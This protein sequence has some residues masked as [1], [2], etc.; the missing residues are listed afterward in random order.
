MNVRPLTF[1][2]LP[3][4][5]SWRVQEQ[6]RLVVQRTAEPLIDRLAGSLSATVD[7]GS[8]TYLLHDGKTI[9]VYIHLCIPGSSRV[10]RIQMM[11]FMHVAACRSRFEIPNSWRWEWCVPWFQTQTQTQTQT[12]TQT[13]TQTNFSH[14]C[15][16]NKSGWTRV[17]GLDIDENW[18]GVWQT[19]DWETRGSLFRLGLCMTF[20]KP[21]VAKKWDGVTEKWHTSCRLTLTRRLQ[22]LPRNFSLGYNTL[23]Q[24]GPQS[25]TI[26]PR[27]SL[28]KLQI[29]PSFRLSSAWKL[30][31]HLIMYTE[32]IREEIFAILAQ[33]CIEN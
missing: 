14:R 23:V 29:E 11:R 31:A 16:I 8:C 12:H 33:R 4:L 5:K 32:S 7:S 25:H 18:T 10:W 20:C 24:S 26:F 19:D 6:A 28:G 13:Q 1:S 3:G 9:I 17:S 27:H 21:R 15:K 30:H 22:W 2:S